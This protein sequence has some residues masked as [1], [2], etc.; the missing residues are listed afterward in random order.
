MSLH[1]RIQGLIEEIIENHIDRIDDTINRGFLKADIRNRVVDLKNKLVK[2]GEIS[3][4]FVNYIE[5][6]ATHK[7][8][9]VNVDVIKDRVL[10]SNIG[11]RVGI[12]DMTIN[13]DDAYD[14]AM[15]GI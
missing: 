8:I 13:H 1:D 12:G 3:S 11:C 2:A 9:I 6:F 10:L 15:A 7:T 5:I 14:R 4:M